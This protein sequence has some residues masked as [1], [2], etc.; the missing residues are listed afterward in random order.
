MKRKTSSEGDGIPAKKLKSQM[1]KS[2]SSFD[3]SENSSFDLSA[4]SELET[5]KRRKKKK[6]RK[7][8]KEKDR[9]EKDRKESRNKSNGELNQ[10]SELKPECKTAE[11]KSDTVIEGAAVPNYY[12]DF[13]ADDL[14]VI[15]KYTNLEQYLKTVAKPSG[16]TSRLAMTAYPTSNQIQGI[17]K[18]DM[19]TKNIQ[20]I[21]LHERRKPALQIT[22][23]SDITTYD[24]MAELA[25]IIH[26]TMGEWE[27][28]FVPTPHPHWCFIWQEQASNSNLQPKPLP[29]L[30]SMS[31]QPKEKQASLSNTSPH[32]IPNANPPAMPDW[33]E[34]LS[35]F[36]KKES[37]E[38]LELFCNAL[39]PLPDLPGELL[40]CKHLHTY[41]KDKVAS[42]QLPEGTE[43]KNILP[44][45]TKADG[46][47]LMNALST[48]VYGD[49]SHAPEIRVRLTIE[50]IKNIELYLDN[51]HLQKGIELNKEKY[52]PTHYK[53]MHLMYTPDPED[54]TTLDHTR[55]AY[56]ENVLKCSR[57]GVWSSIWQIH[58]AA[59]VLKRIIRSV[60]PLSPSPSHGHVEVR[61]DKHRFVC[62]PGD[63]SNQLVRIMWCSH[64]GEKAICDH[65]V[66]LVPR[67]K[68]VEFHSK[69]VK[70]MTV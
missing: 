8:R 53:D 22:P 43:F 21:L 20:K 1:T 65:F 54:K 52:L 45:T 25:K 29:K 48:A 12:K 37:Y 59:G 61:N 26:P 9:K 10:S 15:R 60:A 32:P 2:E 66:L 56:M 33:N 18:G 14:T 64:T 35:E 36:E 40:G 68:R 24:D 6:D 41:V 7:D 34:Y 42:K 4:S 55:V 70:K 27:V 69:Q 30:P 57:Q 13:S 19:L 11:L 63:M 23:T 31:Q 47:C 67:D 62:P 50:A 3:Q 44:V 16:I 39:P 38:E 28:D 51:E 17:T 5:T 46:N 58:Q 49:D